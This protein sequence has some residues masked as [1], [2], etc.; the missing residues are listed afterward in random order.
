[1]VE[2]TPWKAEPNQGEIVTEIIWKFSISGS[3]T[4]TAFWLDFKTKA[5]F[6][7]RDP[8]GPP[9]VMN[10]NGAVF[11]PTG[12]TLQSTINTPLNKPL[13]HYEYIIKFELI[14][15]TDATEVEVDPGYRVWP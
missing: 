3:A 11:S 7:Y 12:G 4:F 5:H 2:V 14:D 8:G 10:R 6:D 1:L 15:G 9:C 13:K